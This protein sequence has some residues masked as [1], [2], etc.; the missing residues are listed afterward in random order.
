MCRKTD[1]EEK[2]GASA[3]SLELS[4]FLQEGLG[5]LHIRRQFEADPVTVSLMHSAQQKG[6]KLPLTCSA[7][8]P[9]PLLCFSGQIPD[10]GHFGHGFREPIIEAADDGSLT[11]RVQGTEETCEHGKAKFFF[12]WH[13]SYPVGGV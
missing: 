7:Q 4:S 12:S 3:L 9:G 10:F 5:R 13:S 2:G 8:F 11:W 1:V 6:A